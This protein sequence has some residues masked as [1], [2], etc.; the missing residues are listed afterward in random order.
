MC[1]WNWRDEDFKRIDY[2]VSYKTTQ[3][4]I[5]YKYINAEDIVNVEIII[6]IEA[7]FVTRV[8][9]AEKWEVSV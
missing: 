2:T 4:V 1:L 8:T 7:I 6:I 5:C 3:L 9:Y